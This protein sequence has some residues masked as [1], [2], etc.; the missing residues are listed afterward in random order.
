[1]GGRQIERPPYRQVRAKKG[2][3]WYYYSL[4]LTAFKFNCMLIIFFYK[5]NRMVSEDSMSVK[6]ILMTNHGM[7]LVHLAPYQF[8]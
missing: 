7:Y 8:D 3:Y 6:C 2:A 1:M 5:F 4:D